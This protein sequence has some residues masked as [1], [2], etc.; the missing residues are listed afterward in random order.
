W[1]GPPRSVAYQTPTTGRDRRKREIA[2]LQRRIAD[3]VKHA[4]R[5]R[6]RLVRGL[7]AAENSVDIAR[8]EVEVA[9]LRYERGLSNNL[10][11]VT[12][13]GNLLGAQSRRIQVL[14]DSAVAGLSLRAVLGI[15]NPRNLELGIS[16]LECGTSSVEYGPRS[17]E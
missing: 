17:R 7:A 2:T 13:E 11:V 4:I 12:A 3:D 10:D 14:A 6:D 15:L 9:Q 16:N 8:K 5:E 1:V